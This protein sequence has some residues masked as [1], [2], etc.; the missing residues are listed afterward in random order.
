MI[1]QRPEP[2]EGEQIIATRTLIKT[3]RRFF[4][5]MSNT[6]NIQNGLDLR[7]TTEKL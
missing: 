2:A 6:Q 5:D 1:S 3:L 4:G 7:E